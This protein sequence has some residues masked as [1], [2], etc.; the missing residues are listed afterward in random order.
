MALA[1]ASAMRSERPREG[2]SAGLGDISD[3]APRLGPARPQPGSILY[4]TWSTM[5]RSGAHA[6]R[7]ALAA[8]GVVRAGGG[9]CGGSPTF[10]SISEGFSGYFGVISRGVQTVLAL[11]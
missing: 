2:S 6:P 7:S 11:G 9:A 3:A 1:A 8:G 5:C 4:A 10:R